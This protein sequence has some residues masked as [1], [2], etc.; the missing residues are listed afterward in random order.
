MYQS[1]GTFVQTGTSAGTITWR[2]PYL[3]NLKVGSLSAISANLGTVTS[4]SLNIGSGRFIVDGSG[5][6]T[7][8]GAGTYGME[9][10]SQVIKI[11]DSTTGALR[12]QLGNLDI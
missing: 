3:S 1:D 11:F 10:N 7:I 5:N 12:V 4:G 8:K 6:V 9:I 2:A